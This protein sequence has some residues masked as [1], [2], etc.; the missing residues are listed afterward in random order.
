MHEQLLEAAKKAIGDLF[1]DGKVP[2]ETT[3]QDMKELRDL[4][5]ENI[6]ML[7]SDLEL[8]TT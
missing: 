1:S 7:E 4:I 2:L 5:D 3:L 8:S 6:E